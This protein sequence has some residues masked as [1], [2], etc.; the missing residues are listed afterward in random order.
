MKTAKDIAQWV[1]DNRW[2]KGEYDKVSDSE[3]YHE[4][5]ERIEGISDIQ[6]IT[7]CFILNNEKAPDICGHYKVIYTDGVEGIEFFNG[8]MWL[9][10]YNHPVKLWWRLRL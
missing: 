10:E 7:G 4:L 6:T 2:P 1:I 9:I 5:V 3:M 8:N